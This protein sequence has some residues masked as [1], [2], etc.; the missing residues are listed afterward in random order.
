MDLDGVWCSVQMETQPVAEILKC[1]KPDWKVVIHDT[2]VLVVSNLS[3]K[4]SVGDGISEVEGVVT[5]NEH[6][7]G[8]G[9]LI[10]KSVCIASER[11]AKELRGHIRIKIEKMENSV[12]TTMDQSSAITFAEVGGQ[13]DE[14]QR[15]LTFRKAKKIFLGLGLTK[16]ENFN[17]FLLWY[18]R[19]WTSSGIL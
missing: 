18:E 6:L 1:T 11:V 19:I 9:Y 10:D 15:K 12:G 5:W 3:V 13:I 17:V 2:V 7:E 8:P 4:D 16:I 14:Y